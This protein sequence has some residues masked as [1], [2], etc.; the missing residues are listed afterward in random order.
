MSYA[1][2]GEFDPS[3]RIGPEDDTFV[4]LPVIPRVGE[5][6]PVPQQQHH[7][8]HHQKAPVPIKVA[9]ALAGCALLFAASG[10]T[11]YLAEKHQGPQGPSA[12][13]T[14]FDSDSATPSA[15]PSA[16]KAHPKH[17]ATPKA[18]ASTS[19]SPSAKESASASPHATTASKP[20]TTP[21]SAAPTHKATAS[22]TAS[23]IP[24]FIWG[25]ATS[26]AGD[27]NTDKHGEVV[28]TA[29]G[30]NGNASPDNFIVLEGLPVTAV[31]ETNGGQI[32]VTVTGRPE[33]MS[34]DALYPQHTGHLALCS[35][36]GFQ[37]Q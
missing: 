8:Y 26:S 16:T 21:T 34:P 10:G 35:T 12:E 19:E 15:S 31:C 1:R 30:D 2:S 9:A 7:E 22:P 3:R 5:F 20:H 36:V 37:Y 13:A 17:T 6:R 32:G 25:C 18:S 28:T 24:E 23:H 11:L 27:Q 4:D 29:C 33:V 14:P